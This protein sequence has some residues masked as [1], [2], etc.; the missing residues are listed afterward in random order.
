VRS[1]GK[2]PRGN[3]SLAH[4]FCGWALTGGLEDRSGVEDTKRVEGVF[5]LV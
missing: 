3:A 1:S 2:F 5:D 4:T